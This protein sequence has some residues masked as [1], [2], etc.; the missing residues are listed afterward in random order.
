MTWR[1]WA[2][3]RTRTRTRA[4]DGDDHAVAA[5]PP[6]P[7]PYMHTT[8]AH[9]QARAALAATQAALG[10][11]GPIASALLPPAAGREPQ[12]VSNRISTPTRKPSIGNRQIHNK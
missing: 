7:P 9:T 4:G 12:V 2:L 5:C 1:R 6:P 8:R 3:T 10:T 11:C